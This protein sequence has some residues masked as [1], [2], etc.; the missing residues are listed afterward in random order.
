MKRQKDGKLERQK[1]QKDR[2]K[3]G[4]IKRQKTM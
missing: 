2:K 3:D 4:K 1:R